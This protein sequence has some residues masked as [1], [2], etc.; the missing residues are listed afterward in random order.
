MYLQH[1][2]NNNSNNISFLL[3]LISSNFFL[4]SEKNIGVQSLAKLNHSISPMTQWLEQSHFGKISQ[5]CAPFE[6]FHLT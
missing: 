3:E 5:I 1:Q 6:E 4:Q 2:G